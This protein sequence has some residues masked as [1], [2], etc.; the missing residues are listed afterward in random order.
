MWFLQSPPTRVAWIEIVILSSVNFSSIVATREEVWIEISMSSIRSSGWAV[1]TREGGVDWN[2]RQLMD[3]L[4]ESMSPPASETWIEIWN[5][6][7]IWPLCRSPPAREVW[8]E[9]K[10]SD[11]LLLIRAGRYPRGWRGLKFPLVTYTIMLLY[12]HP[13]GRRG[14]KSVMVFICI[15]YYMSP[16]VWEA[17][18][19]ALPA[20]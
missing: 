17:R 1:A 12:H 18:V 6:G 10:G 20:L 16:P 15:F 2:K 13:H 9:I 4:Q 11:V 3:Y 14:L 19:E 7:R 8:I 5:G